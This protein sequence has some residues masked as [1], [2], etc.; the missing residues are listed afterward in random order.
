MGIIEYATE[1]NL[2]VKFIEDKAWQKQT[3]SSQVE[4]SLSAICRLAS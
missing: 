4:L 3:L 2:L 1:I